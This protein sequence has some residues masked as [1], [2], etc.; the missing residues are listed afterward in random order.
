VSCEL[1]DTD[2]G[3]LVETFDDQVAALVA[4][5]ELIAVNAD[6]YPAML[7]LLA[8]DERGTLSTVAAGDALGQ[9][10]AKTTRPDER[11]SH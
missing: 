5:R 9:L 2:S 4:A 10:A 11:Q 6:V 7:T 3:N 8:I 1:W